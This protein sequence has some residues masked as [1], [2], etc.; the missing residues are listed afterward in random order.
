MIW[1]TDLVEALELDNLICQTASTA[2]S[3]VN[4]KESHGVRARE[5]FIERA[6]EASMKNTLACVGGQRPVKTD[7]RPVEP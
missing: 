5:D 1:N 3:A 2:N 4:R 6:D 7:Y